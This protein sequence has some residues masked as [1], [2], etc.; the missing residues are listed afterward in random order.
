[1]LLVEV[2]FTVSRKR[3]SRGGVSELGEMKLGNSNNKNNQPGVLRNKQTTQTLWCKQTCPLPANLCTFTTSHC[4]KLKSYSLED[5]LTNY[6]LELYSIFTPQASGFRCSIWPHCCSINIKIKAKYQTRP[7]RTMATVQSFG[8]WIANSFGL[9]RKTIPGDN[10]PLFQVLRQ[11]SLSLPN[12]FSILLIRLEEL[13][14]LIDCYFL[15]MSSPGSDRSWE[16]LWDLGSFNL[17]STCTEE[18]F[19][20]I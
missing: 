16:S 19:D 5:V 1:M 18:V 20:C 7:M 11:F 12:L 6:Y 9:W 10:V 13:F 14:I 8:S 15:K 4:G 2:L 17:S 3:P